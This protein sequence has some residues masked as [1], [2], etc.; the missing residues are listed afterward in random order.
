[1][2]KAVLVFLAIIACWLAFGAL[3]IAERE[4]VERRVPYAHVTRYGA[5]SYRSQCVRWEVRP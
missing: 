4:C 2:F 5:Y 1:M 3:W